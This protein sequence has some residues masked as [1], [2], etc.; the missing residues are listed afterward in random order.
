MKWN[1]AKG[2][3]DNAIERDRLILIKVVRI[4]W[5][6]NV[7]EFHVC[8]FRNGKFWFEDSDDLAY[9]GINDIGAY[10]H[11]IYWVYFDEMLKACGLD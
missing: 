4:S 10:A 2:L 5:P 8:K 11:E 7:I 9:W 1:N 6:E 3:S